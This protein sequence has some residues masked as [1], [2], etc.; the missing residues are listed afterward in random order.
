MALQDIP[1]SSSTNIKSVQHDPDT[2]Q[3][4]VTFHNGGVYSYDGVDV[5]KAQG[6][7]SAESAGKYLHNNVK[8]QHLHSKIG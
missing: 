6:F 2:L 5:D 3:L 7:S 1:I 8:G 4:V